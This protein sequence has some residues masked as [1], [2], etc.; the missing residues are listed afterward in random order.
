MSE[1]ST[2]TP[3]RWEMLRIVILAVPADMARAEALSA[4]PGV[5]LI[6]PVDSPA[7]LAP[8]YA[9][10]WVTA[11]ASYSE[12]FGIVMIES[13]ATGRPIVGRDDGGVPEII[14][15]DENIGRLFSGDEPAEVARALLEGLQLAEDPGTRERCRARAADFTS[16]I[17][18][19]RHVE[20]YRELIG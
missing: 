4:E 14:D 1:N 16:A 19:A 6:D 9:R 18:G 3:M 15:G 7:A 20:L 2:S 13:L 5:E 12:A 8:T 10:G 17:C 11:L